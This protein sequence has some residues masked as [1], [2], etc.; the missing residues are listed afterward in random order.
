[1]TNEAPLEHGE[2]LVRESM[3]KTLAAKGCG[4]CY[5]Q[6]CQWPDCSPKAKALLSATPSPPS[7]GQEKRDESKR[8]Y[9]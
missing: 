5:P 7:Y 3:L 6:D 2:R 4:N 1:M 9:Q 8:A